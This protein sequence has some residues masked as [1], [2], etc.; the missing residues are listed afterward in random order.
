MLRHER[1]RP[2]EPPATIAV[3]ALSSSGLGVMARLG[4]VIGKRTEGAEVRQRTHL[5]QDV[6]RRAPDERAA[7]VA[8]IGAAMLAD[9][10]V[11]A[12]LVDR[13]PL[14]WGMV[15]AIA[16]L[17]CPTGR[18]AGGVLRR[19]LAGVVAQRGDLRWGPSEA[20]WIARLAWSSEVPYASHRIG[21]GLLAERS[22][23]RDP[24]VAT[25]AATGDHPFAAVVDEVTR[26]WVLAMA[27]EEL[28]TPYDRE[29][30]AAL[31]A[32]WEVG[33]R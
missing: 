1:P 12:A 17:P 21:I 18:R 26:R 8:S 7:L 33:P 25:L 15:A 20:A 11:V 16:T 4:P 10:E 3:P 24:L 27:T 29:R 28:R 23:E 5:L 9:P 31:S 19:V 2:P 30:L 14:T 6:A 22:E 32:R 13:G